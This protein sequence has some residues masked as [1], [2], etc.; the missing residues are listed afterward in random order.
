MGNIRKLYERLLLSGQYRKEEVYW[1][2][3]LKDHPGV[4]GFPHRMKRGERQRDYQPETYDIS[5]DRQICRRLL[6]LGNQSDLRLHLILLAAVFWLLHKYSGERDLIIGIPVLKQEDCRDFVNTVLPVRDSIDGTDCFKDLLIRLRD[7]V[8]GAVSHQNYPVELL[9][10]HLGLRY[11]PIRPFPLFDVTVILENIHDPRDLDHV[12]TNM[13]FSFLREGETVKGTV[14]FN[15]RLFH[16]ETIRGVC[17]HLAH[18][19]ELVT[20]NPQLPVAD[21]D[22][23]LK[24]ERERLWRVFDHTNVQFPAAD[25]ILSLFGRQVET[26]PGNIAVCCRDRQLTYGYL[27]RMAQCLASD[28]A[29][30]GLRPGTIVALL[31]KRSHLMIPT[32][33]AALKFG[34]AY[35]PVDPDFPAERIAFMAKDSG[36]ALI[37]GDG[38]SLAP[39]SDMGIPVMEIDPLKKYSI[40]GERDVT[41]PAP[42][43]PAYIIYTSGT[44]GK[45]K[46]VV[47]S[48]KNVVRL[49]RHQGNLFDFYHEDVW[50]MFHSYCFDFSVWE[51]YGA[52]LAGGRLVMVPRETAREPLTFRKLLARLRVTVLNQT[53][54]AF[55]NLSSEEISG[56][57][58]DLA[59]RYVIFGGE[60]LHPARLRDWGLRYPNCRLVNMFGITETTV[61]VTYKEIGPL[62]M[63]TDTCNIGRPLPTLS[64]LVLDNHKRLTPIGVAGELYVGGEGV[65]LGYLN[66]PE[67]T[68]QRFVTHP[69][70]AGLVYRSGDLARV[71]DTMELEYLG[72]I[73]HQVQVRGFRVELGEIEARVLD[74]GEISEAV[75]AARDDEEHNTVLICYFISA[76][77]VDIGH[78]R[79]FLQ[80]RLTD[81][82][83][84]HYFV[85]IDTL[86]LTAN[87]KLDHAAL[88]DPR[89]DG[90][91]GF[92]APRDDGERLLVE[93]WQEVLELD[94]VGIRDN[95]FVVGGD[96]IK[97]IKLLTEIND[98]TGAG[99]EIVDLFLN[100]T[101]EKLAVLVA[102]AR[103]DE[104]DPILEEVRTEVEALKQ[105]ILA[106]NSLGETVEDMFPMSDIQ[107]GMAFL[108]LRDRD[109]GVYHDQMVHQLNYP[110]FDAAVFRRSLEM[111]VRKHEIL[112]TSFNLD[113]YGVPVQMVYSDIPLD[114]DHHDL[115][116]LDRPK[117][118]AFLQT[119][120]AEDR[121]RPFD[122]STPPLWRFRTFRLDRER[123]VVLWVCHHAIIDGWSDAS[124]KTELNNLYTQLRDGR[125]VRLRTLQNSYKTFV[126]EQLAEK[127]KGEVHDFWKQELDDYKRL[128]FN[129]DPSAEGVMKNRT[130]DLGE[131]FYRGCSAVAEELN[132]TVKTIC[133]AAYLY[134][135]YMIS[136][137]PDLLV[138]LICHNRP[139]CEDSEKI[140]GCFLNTLPVRFTVPAKIDGA[141]FIRRVERKFLE[142]KPYERLP[143]FEIVKLTGED[144]GN[145]NPLFDTVFN[146]MDF[147]VYRDIEFD[148]EA[149]DSPD[150]ERMDIQGFVR[151][152][153]PV[154]LDVDATLGAFVITFSYHTGLVDDAAAETMCG[155]FKRVMEFL[156]LNRS[157]PLERQAF[158]DAG[159]MER[160][161]DVGAGPQLENKDLMPVHERL[162]ALLEGREDHIALAGSLGDANLSYGELHRRAT[163][164]ARRLKQLGAGADHIIPLMA[165]PSAEMVVGILGILEA[166]AAYLPLDPGYPGER[167]DFILKDCDARLVVAHGSEEKLAGF[168]GDIVPV[169]NNGQV[170]GDS[171]EQERNP[172]PLDSLAYVI[173]T[174]GSTGTPKGV[175][176]EHRN[177]AW[178][179]E[180]FAAQFKLTAGDTV[181]QQASFTFDAFVEELYPILLAGG[182]LAVPL[183]EEILDSRLLERFIRRHRVTMITCSPLLLNELN[184]LESPSSIHTYI[185]GGDR[186]DSSFVHHLVSKGRVFNTYGPTESTVCATYSPVD[187]AEKG[188]LP[189]GTPIRGARVYVLDR[190]HGIL[191]MGLAGELAIAGGGVSRGYLNRPQL[192]AQQFIPGPFGGEGNMYLSGDL[193]RFRDDGQLEFLGRI[194]RQVKIRGYRIEMGEVERHLLNHDHVDAAVVTGRRDNGAG[195]YLCAY[196][197]G[198][199]EL[200]VAVLRDHLSRRVPRYM[201]PDRFVFVDDIP[202]TAS[203]KPDHKALPQPDL[204]REG[205]YQ[206]PIGSLET[207]LA[208]LFAEVLEIDNGAVGIADDFFQLG[209]HSLKATILTSRIHKIFGV[210]APISVFFKGPTV[211]DLAQFILSS[212]KSD[213]DAV[214]PV[215]KK[216]YYALSSAQKRLYFLQNL[217]PSSTDYNF[218]NIMKLKGEIHRD[219]IQRVFR[220]LIQR[221]ECFRTAIQVKDNQPVQRIYDDVDFEVEYCDA[222]GHRVDDLI[223]RFIRPFDLKQPPFLR[224]TIIRE[225]ELETIVL[226]EMHHI[227]T[228]PVSQ[229]IVMRDFLSLYRGVDLPPLH[230]QYKDY[231]EHLQ[232]A[233]SV[234][235]VK[236]QEE[237]WLR[238][239][240]TEP[241]ELNLPV[242][243]DRKD[244]G[245]YEGETVNS[246]I[247]EAMLAQC[248]LVTAETDATTFMFL[249]AVFS[250]L[251]SRYSG[252]EDIVIGTPVEGRNR[253]ELQT[254]VGFFGN[255]LP[256]RIAP[257]GSKTFRSF[258][259]DVKETVIAAFDNQ[260]YQ[261]DDLINTLGL[262]GSK[263]RNPLFDCVLNVNRVAETGGGE[264]AAPPEGLGFEATPFALRR[265]VLPFDLYLNVLEEERAVYLNLN[266][267]TG[268]FKNSTAESI[269]RHF[270]DTIDQVTKQPDIRLADIELSHDLLMTRP[271]S[272]RDASSQFDFSGF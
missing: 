121:Q 140:L 130:F 6:R 250:F 14:T 101:V 189:I 120:I 164:L 162:A 136:W 73:D 163:D 54:S 109:S 131:Q 40:L 167:I 56:F 247:E 77:P 67:L 212:G 93:I 188:P 19:L 145:G 200:T 197:N 237:Y 159:D 272:A 148:P 158:I 84:P 49:L 110:D 33:L 245:V 222:H 219:K 104:S 243:F 161:L 52:L 151:T 11:T 156:V 39:V 107:E 271:D 183:E 209:G 223:R 195:E 24:G 248:K 15:N 184:S 154:N 75:V 59:V 82:M 241:P 90:E 16:I 181:I 175:L 227:L 1:L 96:S 115:T 7:S 251:L 144:R 182:T 206:A 252:P 238:Q 233:A 9:L 146:F 119:F 28:M 44:T 177:L 202:L 210:R 117:Q 35:L 32:I 229:E 230:L 5:F 37:V 178:Y 102:E 68:A 176:V 213:Y 231:T 123:V 43:D 152:N 97:A 172:Q 127:R 55:Y 215:E 264:G 234:L 29:A 106:E 50:T 208:D 74:Y 137:E 221:Y 260:D 187:P 211:K 111:M 225:G 70:A 42:E 259:V 8:G 199:D 169:K 62:E 180:A 23:L 265:T 86:P 224:V 31:L 128:R 108:Y 235:A 155:Y 126:L 139:V 13:G 253:M 258:L 125:N 217:D 205:D 94:A 190:Y 58:N 254:V 242:D 25:T 174:S 129:G 239:F 262:Q 185:S 266:F 3:L 89:R 112:R 153:T 150:E 186:L 122:M 124:F 114:F 81:Y 69:A 18:L 71:M 61:H 63:D 79:D 257:F 34:C 228:D 20:D 12:R 232:S 268:L 157:Q 2:D 142:L 103:A 53:P 214:E 133:F 193:A 26:R 191:P 269:L 263:K 179:M 98:A 192:T 236:R 118:E 88:P 143:F 165:E 64:A 30:H 196:V 51:M 244:A 21:V 134:M 256:M 171:L 166:N 240:D 141:A 4:R 100:E 65:S 72:R 27:E 85:G 91:D 203:G 45:P 83:M 46:G 113:D 48:H 47:V 57:P 38:D 60:E 17:A 66:R 41:K 99:L 160:L 261:F 194:D 216:D 207:R 201:I 249:L 116:H 92:L 87:G 173:Y 168:A 255:I 78:L 270:M 105:R 95:F 226:W 218:T 149:Q 198:A 36:A 147:H 246:V 22:I 220:Q 170:P 80:E 132:T 267:S 204:Q 10:A 135:L 138:G 76:S